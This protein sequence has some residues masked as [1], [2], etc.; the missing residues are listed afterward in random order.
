MTKPQQWDTTEQDAEERRRMAQYV[1][2][3][4]RDQQL[5]H[6]RCV[7]CAFRPGTEANRSRVVL[8]MIEGCLLMHGTFNCH[9][10]HVRVRGGF[11]NPRPGQE[12]QM[13]A[14]FMSLYSTRAE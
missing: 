3:A 10:G 7:T 8:G 14:G 9:A 13:C 5:A 4:E 11:V 6:R 2:W 1:R 12:K